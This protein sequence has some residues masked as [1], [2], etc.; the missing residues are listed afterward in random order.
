MDDLD[1][2]EELNHLADT[3]NRE[4]EREL[5]ESTGRGGARMRWRRIGRAEAYNLCS[6]RIAEFNR[7]LLDKA[8]E[9]RGL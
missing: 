2:V 7:K 1:L 9:A 5:A 8:R 6:V 4:G 3:L